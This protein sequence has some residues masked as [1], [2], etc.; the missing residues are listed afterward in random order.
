MSTAIIIEWPC[1][2]AQCMAVFQVPVAENYPHLRQ[3]A[4]TCPGCARELMEEEKETICDLVAEKA[5]ADVA[6]AN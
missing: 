6:E 2:T 1:C 4:I 5:T 3:E